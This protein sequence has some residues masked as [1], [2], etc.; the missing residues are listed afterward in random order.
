MATFAPGIRP[1]QW[2]MLLY[3]SCWQDWRLLL[4]TGLTKRVCWSSSRSRELSSLVMALPAEFFMCNAKPQVGGDCEP[5]KQEC[6]RPGLT[7]PK[8]PCYGQGGSA[9]LQG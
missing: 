9:R 6:E 5:G 4:P 1:V 8:D 3:H 7:G 2:N